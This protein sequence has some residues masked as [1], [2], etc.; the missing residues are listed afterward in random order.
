[1]KN[2]F[3]LIFILLVTFLTLSAGSLTLHGRSPSLLKLKTQSNSRLLQSIPFLGS[4]P[5]SISNVL[6]IFDWVYTENVTLGSGQTTQSF[7][8]VLDTGISYIWLPTTSDDEETNWDFPSQY[9]CSS[10]NG[11]T[12]LNNATNTTFSFYQDNLTGFLATNELTIGTVS[13]P[14]QQIVLAT[15]VGHIFNDFNNFTTKN[16]NLNSPA[17]DGFFGLGPNPQNNNYTTFIDN[18]FNAGI[19]TEKWFSIYITVDLQNMDEE[20]LVTFEG[21]N[22]TYMVNN[23]LQYTNSSSNTS[24]MVPISNASYSGTPITT[25]TPQALIASGVPFI[26]VDLATFANLWN[27]LMYDLQI[28]CEQESP[29]LSN[30]T[31]LILCSCSGGD[32]SAFPPLNFT[33]NGI[34]ISLSAAYYT[35]YLGYSNEDEESDSN[36]ADDTC[37]FN[38]IPTT[39]TFGFGNANSTWIL[40]SP[41]LQAYYTIFNASDMTIG[42]AEIA[43][44]PIA[45]GKTDGASPFI[46][47]LELVGGMLIALAVIVAIV[48]ACKPGGFL[49]NNRDRVNDGYYANGNANANQNAIMM[50]NQQPLQEPGVN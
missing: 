47:I 4:S 5:A 27:I 33:I 37:M 26:A 42:F 15:Q 11:C 13:L 24:W 22:S 40:G 21:Y 6:N 25:A 49:R 19:I 3:G 36:D 50:N 18:L 34:N 43:Q 30:D 38:I 16:Y 48:K 9:T 14:S 32:V 8:L 29:V 35:Q 20:S 1:M 12:I 23:T 7:N 17:Y 41:F 2:H 10:D 46:N 44:Q 28:P 31:G 39:Y 45:P